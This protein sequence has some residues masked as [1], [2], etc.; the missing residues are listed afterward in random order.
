MF[1]QMHVCRALALLAL[2]GGGCEH[3]DAGPPE[4]QLGKEHAMDHDMLDGEWE[5]VACQIGGVS[6]QANIGARIQI[7]DGVIRDHH[8]PKTSVYEY[9]ID[10]SAT[11]KRMTW[12]LVGFEV[13]GAMQRIPMS[14][15]AATGIY[16]LTATEL[17]FCWSTPDRSIPKTFSVSDDP[18]CHMY[19]YRRA[20]RD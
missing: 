4:R 2:L 10:Q 15:P 13:D 6:N 11:P 3:H 19:V 12:K 8:T 20:N 7:R 16:E 18:D 1:S 9:D 5:V 17:K 14:M